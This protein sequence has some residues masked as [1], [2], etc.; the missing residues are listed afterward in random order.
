VLELADAE[1]VIIP[2]HGPIADRDDLIAYRDMLTKARD[3]ISPL[4]ASPWRRSSPRHR[5]RN[6]TPRGAE[7]SSIPSASTG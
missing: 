4:M 2:G 3:A 7:D 5:R 6:L 1:T